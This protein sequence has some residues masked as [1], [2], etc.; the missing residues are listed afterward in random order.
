MSS[1][2]KPTISVRIFKGLNISV[3]KNP[4][5]LLNF[6][7]IPQTTFLYVDQHKRGVVWEEINGLIFADGEVSTKTTKIKAP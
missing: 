1:H 2:R 5:Q 4:S 3:F 6:V 7:G